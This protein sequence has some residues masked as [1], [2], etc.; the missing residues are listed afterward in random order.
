M[1]IS[2][3][4]D[5]VVVQY[6][7]RWWKK[8]DRKREDFDWFLKAA[9]GKELLTKVCDETPELNITECKKILVSME[10]VKMKLMTSHAIVNRDTVERNVMKILMNVPLILANMEAVSTWSMTIFV[11]VVLDTREQIVMKI[12]MNVPLILANMEAVST[13]SMTILVNVVLDTREQI[14]MKIL[15]NVPLILANME[16]VLTWSMTIF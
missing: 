2:D 8:K 4:R 6:P 7:P 10:V 14:V 16:A 9:F 1:G 11:N 15:M 13:R 3:S 5:R 12:L